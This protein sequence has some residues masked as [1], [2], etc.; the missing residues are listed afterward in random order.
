MY[1]MTWLTP[2]INWSSIG[3]THGLL[4]SLRMAR[5]LRKSNCPNCGGRTV[6]RL[7]WRWSSRK[8]DSSPISY[9]NCAV[10]ITFIDENAYKLGNYAYYYLETKLSY[11]ITWGISTSSL[12][13]NASIRRLTMFFISCKKCKN[14][15]HV[16]KERDFI[17]CETFWN[18]MNWGKML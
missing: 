11:E 8:L 15:W 9:N 16:Q 5:E 3:G 4:S 17:L 10:L 7:P 13:R 18:H 14:L 6:S 1:S 2:N 12:S